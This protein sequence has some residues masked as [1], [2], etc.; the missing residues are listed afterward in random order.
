M[1]SLMITLKKLSSTINRLL[2]GIDIETARL[3]RLLFKIIPTA[4]KIPGCHSSY[5]S[6]FFYVKRNIAYIRIIIS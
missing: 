3:N 5:Y 2:T 1:G 6:Q 4:M